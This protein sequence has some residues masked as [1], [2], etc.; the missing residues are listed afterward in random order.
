MG[1]NQ[2]KF[3]QRLWGDSF[4]NSTKKMSTNTQHPEGCRRGFCKYIL[5]PLTQLVAR[6]VQGEKQRYI[7]MMGSFSFAGGG[8][9]SHWTTFVEANGALAQCC[10]NMR[11]S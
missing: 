10:A 8:D 6:I 1:V 7:A 9:G 4:Y 11:K 5:G 2:E 3:A